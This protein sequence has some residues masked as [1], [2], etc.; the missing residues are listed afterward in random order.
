MRLR[1]RIPFP[2]P[3]SIG[4]SIPLTGG[5]RRSSGGGEAGCITT[6]FMLLWW[7]LVFEVWAGWWILKPFYIVGVL[8]H[9]KATGRY[10]PIWRSRGGW[11]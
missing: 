1:W 6:P 9:R 8:V 2:G 10:T 4:G 11:W 5:P 7:C 3:F